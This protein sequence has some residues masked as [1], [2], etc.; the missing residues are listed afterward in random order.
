MG[1]PCTY[2]YST[3]FLCHMLLIHWSNNVFKPLFISI[4]DLKLIQWFRFLLIHCFQGFQ[5]QNIVRPKISILE[6]FSPI[7]EPRGKSL[8]FLEQ[9]HATWEQFLQGFFTRI[10][11][12][13]ST[14]CNLYVSF[15]FLPCSYCFKNVCYGVDILF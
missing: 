14:K 11:L 15:Y 7:L 2:A 9:K 12:L 10:S 4:F 6:W 5:I 8:R 13:L 3:P 1:L